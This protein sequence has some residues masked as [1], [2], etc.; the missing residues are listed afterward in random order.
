MFCKQVPEGGAKGFK[1]NRYVLEILR[2]KQSHKLRIDKEALGKCQKHQLPLTIFCNEQGC[3]EIICHTCA[4]LK[5]KSHQIMELSD[6]ANEVKG[7]LMDKFCSLVD[8]NKTMIVERVDELHKIISNLDDA[9]EAAVKNVEERKSL[10]IEAVEKEANEHLNQIS[11]MHD[12]EFTRID[13]MCGDMEIDM[14]KLEEL[15]QL[16]SECRR[17]KGDKE[18][19]EYYLA[20]E[21]M[22]KM[23]VLEH[24]ESGKC[25]ESFKVSQ[26]IAGKLERSMSQ[27]IGAVQTKQMIVDYL[28]PILFLPLDVEQTETN[29]L[30]PDPESTIEKIKSWI[31]NTFAAKDK[32]SSAKPMVDDNDNSGHK[33]HES[34]MK[35]GTTNTNCKDHTADDNINQN[36]HVLEGND[37]ATDED[38]ETAHEIQGND[39]ASNDN[40]HETNDNKQVSNSP[41]NVNSNVLDGNYDRDLQPVATTHFNCWV[42]NGTLLVVSPSFKIYTASKHMVE[43]WDINGHLLKRHSVP[44]DIVGLQSYHSNG[45]DILVLL[46]REST[47]DKVALRNAMTFDLIDTMTFKTMKIFPAMHMPSESTILLSGKPRTGKC[48]IVKCSTFGGKIVL[49]NRPVKIDVPQILSITT[50]RH[51]WI[52]VVAYSEGIVTVDSENGTVFWR[53]DVQCTSLCTDPYDNIFASMPGSKGVYSTQIKNYKPKTMEMIQIIKASQARNVCIT[54]LPGKRNLLFFLDTNRIIHHYLIDYGKPQRKSFMKHFNVKDNR[55]AMVCCF[56]L[57]SFLLSLFIYVITR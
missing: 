12:K 36:N 31:K 34:C 18:T 30:N 51:G 43:V 52:L 8:D 26:F 47:H 10:L 16:V 23:L 44:N 39:H 45:K 37:Q 25:V 22:Y 29:N 33:G 19:I 40:S 50:L 35:N 1:S 49:G 28:G 21:Q 27:T 41:N 53:C 56:A 2:E 20:V 14:W 5:H 55:F 48:R 4:L 6:K 57:A 11:E 13:E 7:P 15:M 46:T 54:Q 17:Q 9:S 38:D 24:E 3:K 42:T 32:C